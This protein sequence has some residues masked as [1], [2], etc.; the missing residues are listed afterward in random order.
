[1][2]KK[3]NFSVSVLVIN[4][5]KE[6]FIARCL[7]SLVN[8]DFKKFEVIFSDDKSTDNSFSIATKFKKKL[9]LKVIKGIKRTMH[10]SYNQMNSI[11]RAFK[12]S[13]GKI[14]LFL[15]SDDFFHKKKIFSIVK[16]FNKP[17]NIDKKIIFDLPYI[18]YS[19]NNIKKFIIK[20]KVSNKLWPQFPPQSCISLKRDF[21]EEIFPK[22]SFNNFFNIWFDFRVAFYS[23]FIS[24][25]FEILDK[26]LTYYFIDPNGVSSNFN[27]LTFNWWIRRLE[28]FEFYKYLFKKFFLQFPLTL[29]YFVTKF[30]S[31][32]ILLFKKS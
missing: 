22:I 2:Y 32:S 28:A 5:N 21:F 7:N 3:K 11:L 18:Y 30:I 15:D 6:K 1:M 23:Y 19:R 9:N 13:S 26:K 16:Y 20:K 27:Y 4:Y 17:D 12:K 10:G 29:D 31:L 14:I 25:N 24:K 8:Q